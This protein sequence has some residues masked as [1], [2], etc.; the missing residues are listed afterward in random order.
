MQ[1]FN[2]VVFDEDAT[3]H[4]TVHA[5]LASR[6]KKHLILQDEEVAVRHFH[7]VVDEQVAIR[8]GA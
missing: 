3:A 8:N 1:V 7:K 6:A 4:E 2:R 5:G